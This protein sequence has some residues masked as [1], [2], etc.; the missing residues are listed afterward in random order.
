MNSPT[1][2]WKRVKVDI[3]VKLYRADCADAEALVVRTFE[4]SGGGLS[5]YVSETFTVGTRVTV[6]IPL[7]GCEPFRAPA[8]V[9]NVRGFRCGLEFPEIKA[10]QRGA[11]M[12]YLS[13]VPDVIEI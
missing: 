1:R 3:R 4:M 10:S 13:T 6:E 7:P 2:K 8:I 5:V 11:I 9:R 12:R